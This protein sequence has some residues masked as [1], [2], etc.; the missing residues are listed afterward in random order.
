MVADDNR[1]MNVRRIIRLIPAVA[2]LAVAVTGG[3][4]GA[5]QGAARHVVMISIDGLKPSTYSTPGPS[6]VPALRRLALAGAYAEG[7]VGALPTVTYPAHTTIITGVLPAVHGIYNNRILDPEDTSNGSWYW[8]AR[9]IKVP[10]LP[11]VFKARGLTTGAVSWP[12]TVGA[13]IDYLVPEFGGVTR[14]P[15]WLEMFRA[16]SSPRGVLEKYE[17]QGRAINWPMSDDDRT[18]LAAWI[19]RTYKP[20]LM[21]LHIFDTDDAQHEY[22]PGSAEALASIEEA[23]ARVEQMIKAIADAGLQ[24][25][26][27]VV[28]VSDHGFLPLEQQLQPNYAFKSAGLLDV[29]DRGRIR[30]WDAYFYTAG[31]G[32]F[33]I[34]RNPEDAS[35]RDKVAAILQKLA[36]DPANGILTVLNRQELQ[37]A[38]ADPRASFFIDMRNGFYSS[39]GHAV[40]LSKTS[41]K[42]GHGFVPSRPE[43]HASLVMSGPDVPKAGSVGVV[44]MSQIGPTIASW[45]QVKLSPQADQ[46]LAWPKSSG[47]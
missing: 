32:G 42:G 20:N 43:L 22:G 34:L 41:G 6:K 23:D 12:V 46:P 18:G 7:V 4:L 19:F 33:V 11:G 31:G 15:K 17:A 14:N 47:R 13:E 44:R 45:F 1:R 38:G 2:A 10:T 21:L 37:K 9:D 39:G 35:L 36:A 40:L 5:Q 25:Q 3:S 26:T 24:G 30:R 27:D 16:L 29:D 28:V 8:Y